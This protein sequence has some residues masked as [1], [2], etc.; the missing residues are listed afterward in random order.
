MNHRIMAIAAIPFAFAFATAAPATASPWDPPPAQPQVEPWPDEGSGWPGYADQP[1]PPQ[2]QVESWPDEGSGWPGY[3]DQ[4]APAQP[5]AES[6]NQATALHTTSIALGA[7]GGI[8]LAGAA[9]GITL[10]V[11]RHRDHTTSTQSA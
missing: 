10:A 9:L 6:I 4:P 8:T 3:A 7:L 1:A 11:Q 2:P 5:P